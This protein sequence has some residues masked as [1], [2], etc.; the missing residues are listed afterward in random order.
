[1]IL[2]EAKQRTYVAGDCVFGIA[3]D[4][5]RDS[6][7]LRDYVSHLNTFELYEKFVRI[8]ELKRE[9]HTITAAN[10]EL[11]PSP[12]RPAIWTLDDTAR[13]ILAKVESAE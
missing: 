3:P 1:V 7:R 5:R 6:L 12:K 9:I 2:K 4:L 10:D 11:V 8:L 13:H